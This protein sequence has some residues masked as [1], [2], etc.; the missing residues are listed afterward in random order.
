MRSPIGWFRDPWRKP[1]VLVGITIFCSWR[2][3]DSRL[4]SW[5]VSTGVSYSLGLPTINIGY[6]RYSTPAVTGNSLYFQG[7]FDW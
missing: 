4:G 3:R 6:Q 2:L 5:L 7:N 1:R